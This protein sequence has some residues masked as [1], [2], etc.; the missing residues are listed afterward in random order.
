[1]LGDAVRLAQ[2]KE[3]ISLLYSTNTLAQKI[4]AAFAIGLTYPLLARRSASIRAST[5]STAPTA[6]GN[7][8]L[9]FICGPILFVILGGACMIGWRLDARRHDE[10]RAQLEA[11]DAH[12]E[13]AAQ[14]I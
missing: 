2:G 6:L 10:I 12:L 7:L 1:M 11:R 8:Q 3:R 9:M 4:A 13:S 5:P 14:I